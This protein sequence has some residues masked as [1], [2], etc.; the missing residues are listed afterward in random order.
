MKK[1]P[2]KTRAGMLFLKVHMRKV[3]CKTYMKFTST[4]NYKRQL[5][6]LDA[7]KK[8]LNQFPAPSPGG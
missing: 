8:V 7:G 1:A 4:K 3:Q 6:C 5:I 2:V